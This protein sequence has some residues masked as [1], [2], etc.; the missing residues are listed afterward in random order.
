MTNEI[1]QRFIARVRH[2]RKQRGLSAEQLSVQAGLSKSTWSN[3]EVPGGG[4]ERYVTLDKAVPVA[5]VLGVPI[6]QLIEGLSD[7]CPQ[8][9]DAP[10]QGFTCQACGASS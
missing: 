6:G 8:C 5:T 10:P 4:Q 1:S 9:N 2:L 3:L 7:S